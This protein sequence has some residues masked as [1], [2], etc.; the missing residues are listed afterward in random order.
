MEVFPLA[1]ILP[2]G[3]ELH[4]PS[5]S[6]LLTAFINEFRWRREDLCLSISLSVVL[7]K[8]NCELGKFAELAE[9]SIS[10]VLITG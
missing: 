5:T 10:E 3:N 6:F 1:Y 8:K 9:S 2:K 4:P 7:F